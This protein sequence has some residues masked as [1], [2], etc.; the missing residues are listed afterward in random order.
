MSIDLDHIRESI[1][2]EIPTDPEVVLQLADEVERLRVDNSRL[3]DELAQAWGLTD[4]DTEAAR[5]DEIADLLSK[6]TASQEEMT[7][8][9]T[10]HR[11]LCFVAEEVITCDEC[12]DCSEMARE[13]LGRTPSE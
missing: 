7:E 8:L 1:D 6:Y 11:K 2:L 10:E 12:P 5:T 3:R 4:A 9:L 13:A